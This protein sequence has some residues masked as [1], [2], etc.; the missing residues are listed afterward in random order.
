MVEA[1]QEKTY[2]VKH[3]HDNMTAPRHKDNKDDQIVI[4]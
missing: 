1:A 3:E 4:F 2:K